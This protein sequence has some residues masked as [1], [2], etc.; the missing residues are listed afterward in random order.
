MRS[1]LGWRANGGLENRQGT[2]GELMLFD[3]GDFI[4]GQFRAWLRK[5][6]LNLRVNHLVE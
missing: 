4:F 2:G 6:L 1:E 5:K 3:L